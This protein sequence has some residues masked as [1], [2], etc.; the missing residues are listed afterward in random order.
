[1]QPIQ[2][3]TFD[4]SSQS[5]TFFTKLRTRWDLKFETYMILECLARQMFIRESNYI[6]GS[7]SENQNLNLANHTS[8]ES[9]IDAIHNHVAG[10]EISKKAAYERTLKL[11]DALNNNDQDAIQLNRKFGRLEKDPL[12]VIAHKDSDGKFIKPDT[13]LIYGKEKVVFSKILKDI[14][15]IVPTES[16][17]ESDQI[18]YGDVSRRYLKDSKRSFGSGG[19]DPGRYMKEI[20]REKYGSSNPVQ[21]FLSPESHDFVKYLIGAYYSTFGPFLRLGNDLNDSNFRSGFDRF[22]AE[23][24]E[25]MFKDAATALSRHGFDFSVLFERETIKDRIKNNS[26]FFDNLKDKA[27]ETVISQDFL[28]Y[29]ENR[30]FSRKI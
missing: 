27:L 26:K 10:I 30:N 1:M 14:E 23:K 28:K 18:K 19:R 24:F 8:E 7:E 4:W 22:V 5:E 17:F 9:Y 16:D 15:D 21:V 29:L 6:F 3:I 13:F 20:T 11:A 2:P 25:Y 12:I